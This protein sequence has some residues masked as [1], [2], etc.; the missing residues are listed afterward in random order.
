M[1]ALAREPS[2]QSAMLSS[3]GSSSP[4]SGED[5]THKQACECWT[6]RLWHPAGQMGWGRGGMMPDQSLLW[7][8]V[9][10]PALGP[11]IGS[12]CISRWRN[13]A[14]PTGTSF[15]GRQSCPRPQPLPATERGWCRRHSPD[16]LPPTAP[17]LAENPPPQLDVRVGP[18]PTF[19]VE[20]ENGRQALLPSPPPGLP[21]PCSGGKGSFPA[22]RA[23]A[24]AVS[25][26]VTKGSRWRGRDRM[27]WPIWREAETEEEEG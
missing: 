27:Y 13:R 15:C 2:Q 12:G 3:S 5:K 23:S 20:G 26:C 19:P 10:T 18:G 8:A 4:G 6:P 25:S 1:V 16:F 14:G 7:V 22:C 11:S 24:K 9:A 17:G 21:L